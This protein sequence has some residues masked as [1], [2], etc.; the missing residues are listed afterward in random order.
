[1]RCYAV[2]DV[3]GYFGRDAATISATLS[4]YDGRVEKQPAMRRKLETLAQTV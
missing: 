3:A 1:M 4:R 2:K